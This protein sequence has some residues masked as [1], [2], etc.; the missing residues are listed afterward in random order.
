ACA[1]AR[2]AAAQGRRP[3][4]H[5]TD[6]RGLARGAAAEIHVDPRR[7]AAARSVS[8]VM[9]WIVALLGALALVG[10]ALDMEALKSVLRDRVAMNPLTAL[11]FLLAAGA[12]WLLQEGAVRRVSSVR[13]AR[14]A[15]CV[16]LTIGVVTAFG[17]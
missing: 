3:G 10:W 1:R 16:V 8:R 13:A 11:G 17:Y 4:R 15:A 14:I 6:G 12:L 5:M 9:C 7:I 2:L